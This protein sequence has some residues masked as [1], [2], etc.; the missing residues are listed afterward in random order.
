MEVNN[1]MNL[2]NGFPKPRIGDIIILE[3]KEDWWTY[4]VWYDDSMLFCINGGKSCMMRINIG[5][6]R[7]ILGRALLKQM[8]Q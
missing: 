4:A 1:N 6:L 8:R 7:D 5:I 2:P 3:Q